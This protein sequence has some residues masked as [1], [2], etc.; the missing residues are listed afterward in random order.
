MA[1]TEE[2]KD[3]TSNEEKELRRVYEHLANFA[4]KYKLRR[5][6]QP[7]TDRRQKIL[8]FKR[9]PDAIRIVDEA[10]VELTSEQL[11]AELEHIEVRYVCCC[12]QRLRV[13][14]V[15]AASPAELLCG[16]P[17]APHCVGCI[18]VYCADCPRAWRRLRCR[19]GAAGDGCV[20]TPRRACSH[21]LSPMH[22]HSLLR[23]P[24]TALIHM[25]DACV[26][27]ARGWHSRACVGGARHTSSPVWRE[28]VLPAPHLPCLLPPLVSPA[29]RLLAYTP[30]VCPLRVASHHSCDAIAPTTPAWL[31][32]VCR[33]RVARRRRGASRA[34]RA[35][36]HGAGASLL[37]WARA[38][39]V[40]WGR[41]HSAARVTSRCV[42][43]SAHALLLPPLLLLLSVSMS[44]GPT[45]PHVPACCVSLWQA[46][47]GTVTAQID[48]INADA[49]KKIHCADLMDALHSLGKDCTKVRHASCC[50]SARACVSL[51][52]CLW[53]LQ[54]PCFRQHAPLSVQCLCTHHAMSVC[55]RWACDRPS[56]A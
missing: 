19:C 17:S 14:A 49:G 34:A 42:P 7:L 2:P 35:V 20:S 8:Q 43:H 25:C 11:D 6:M 45:H 51:R 44:L 55:A 21:G 13:R 10:G 29:R 24:R 16:A 18:A 22:P 30:C 27:V 41:P 5:R 33:G 46:E 52:L 4:P 48:E 47:I 56:Y 3:V 54:C 36:A 26:R 38:C 50:V 23:R 40:V 12:V 31:C 53:L 39:V 32:C 37:L 15:A 9:N 1:E 28:S